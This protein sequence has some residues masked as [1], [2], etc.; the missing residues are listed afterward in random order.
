[1]GFSV[2][3]EAR[4]TDGRLWV[5]A[6]DSGG[7]F[8][9]LPQPAPSTPAPVQFG[10]MQQWDRERGL[11]GAEAQSAMTSFSWSAQDA[12]QTASSQ[13]AMPLL[14]SLR[15]SSKRSL[16]QRCDCTGYNVAALRSIKRRL[17]AAQGIEDGEER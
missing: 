6:G 2:G 8:W 7:L 16:Q 12:Q 9:F 1:M 3:L 13:E 11:H 10:S 14:R 5:C 17:E 4:G 15:A